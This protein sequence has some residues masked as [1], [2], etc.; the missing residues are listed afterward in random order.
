MPF[1][2]L[3]DLF[4]FDFDGLLVNT[5]HLHF[6]AYINV[7]AQEGYTLTWSFANYCEVAHL[8]AEALKNKLYQEFP[9]LDPDWQRL[10]A[11]KKT[12]YIELLYS[13][14]VE[15][16]PGVASLLAAL[17]Q[18]GKQRCVVTHSPLP[19]IQAIRSQH[20]ILQTIPHWITRE[21]Y[22]MPK[23][24]PDGY[25]KAIALYGKAGDRIIGFEDSLRGL[26]SL[27]QTPA[28]AVLICPSRHPLL[29]TLL[30]EGVLHYA[31]LQEFCIDR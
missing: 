13:G 31:T 15:L 21:D 17:Q 20:P 30:E 4:L 6:Q 22:A 11:L 28:T 1:L 2:D 5:E 27:Q 26:R 23:P 29:P 24:A 8:T 3:F 7:L 19:Q 9:D 18:A 10:Y 14:K 25:L 12:M 16:M